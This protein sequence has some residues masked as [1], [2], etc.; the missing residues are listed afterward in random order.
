MLVFCRGNLLATRGAIVIGHCSQ[1]TTVLT[2]S[3]TTAFCRPNLSPAR[4]TGTVRGPTGSIQVTG[5]VTRERAS[6]L[7]PLTPAGWACASGIPRDACCRDA[8]SIRPYSL[9]SEGP[10]P[11]FGDSVGLAFGPCRVIGLQARHRSHRVSS[12]SAHFVDWNGGDSMWC[13]VLLRASSSAGIASSSVWTSS[14]A[15]TNPRRL[16]TPNNDGS[17]GVWGQAGS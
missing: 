6:R 12:S 7:P 11:A 13:M 10:L 1:I 9:V 17:P 8:N 3:G 5:R 15:P 16:R 4:R 2:E 14:A